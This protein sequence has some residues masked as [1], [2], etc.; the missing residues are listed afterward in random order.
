MEPSDRI[1]LSFI[2][3]ETIVLPLNEPG[4]VRTVGIEPTLFLL[5]RQRP[6]HLTMCAYFQETPRPGFGPGISG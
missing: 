3:Y 5:R 1:E 2:D 6:F 4:V